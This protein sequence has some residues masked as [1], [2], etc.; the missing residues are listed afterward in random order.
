M[1]LH[2]FIVYILSNIFFFFTI[3]TWLINVFVIYIIWNYIIEKVSKINSSL[4]SWL[5]L[6]YWMEENEKHM[7]IIENLL[8]LPIVESRLDWMN[9]M[10]DLYLWVSWSSTHVFHC[11]VPFTPYDWAFGPTLDKLWY[12]ALVSKYPC[13]IY[14]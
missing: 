2:K 4:P 13:L 14:F 11:I 12:A 8:Y 10:Y 5:F 6:D 3:I 9:Q 1:N 7:V